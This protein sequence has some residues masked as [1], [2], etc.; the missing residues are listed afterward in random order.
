MS[1]A[2][3]KYQNFKKFGDMDPKIGSDDGCWKTTRTKRSL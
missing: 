2:E 1:L 3:I